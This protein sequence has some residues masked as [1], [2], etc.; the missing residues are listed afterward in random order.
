[1]KRAIHSDNVVKRERNER[2]I[3]SIAARWGTQ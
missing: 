1:M 3:A 2:A